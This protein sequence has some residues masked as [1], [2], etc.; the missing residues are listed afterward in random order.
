[1]RHRKD[2]QFL[3]IRMG[4]GKPSRSNEEHNPIGAKSTTNKPFDGDA[5]TLEVLAH[6]DKGVS[7]GAASGNCC[8]SREGEQRRLCSRLSRAGAVVDGKKRGKGN[9]SRGAV[10]LAG[11]HGG[12]SGP[13]G[14]C[15]FFLD[16]DGKE[17]KEEGKGERKTRWPGSRGAA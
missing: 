15:P 1:M 4:I 13:S 3:S 7:G 9:G 8:R 16:R 11:V 10:A 2:A 6:A 17:E 12:R 14:R 5:F